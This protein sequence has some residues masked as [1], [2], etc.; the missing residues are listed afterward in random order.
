MMKD[1]LLLVDAINDFRH[2]D[3]DKLLESFRER[4]G[5]WIYQL[6]LIAARQN[7]K[8][9]RRAEALERKAR[10]RAEKARIVAERAKRKRR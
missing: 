3:G 10:Q 9:M 7:D 6:E 4:V 2:E 1:A 5:L 8:A